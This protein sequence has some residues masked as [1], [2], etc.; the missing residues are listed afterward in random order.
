MC[1]KEQSCL[2][3]PHDQIWNQKKE[4]AFFYIFFLLFIC[5]CSF[6]YADIF[7]LSLS[8]YNYFIERLL[9][10][11][12]TINSVYNRMFSSICILEDVN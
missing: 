10:I 5:M 7:F 2:C 6:V 12:F 3:Q 8:H 9:E 1:K 11:N 4:K